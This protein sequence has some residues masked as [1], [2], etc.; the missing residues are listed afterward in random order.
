MFSIKQYIWAL[1]LLGI[2]FQTNPVHAEEKL[3][4][5]I[6]HWPPYGLTEQAQISGISYDVGM[7][8]ANRLGMKFEVRVC[9]FKRCLLEMESGSLDLWQV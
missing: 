2:Q 8:V 7:E 4:Y 9:P 5:A 1:F 3:R 6:Y